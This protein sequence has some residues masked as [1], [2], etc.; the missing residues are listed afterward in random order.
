MA[1]SE[2]ELLVIAMFLTKGVGPLISGFINHN[3]SKTS[4]LDDLMME[5][6]IRPLSFYEQLSAAHN[7]I[8]DCDLE[9]SVDICKRISDILTDDSNRPNDSVVPIHCLEKSAKVRKSTLQT[10]VIQKWKSYV[11]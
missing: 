11:Y 4:Q 7:K 9:A 3:L 1:E 5:C 2:R 8:E 6:F 10:S